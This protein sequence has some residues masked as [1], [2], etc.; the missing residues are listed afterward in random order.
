MGLRE[1][2]R[3]RDL[4]VEAVAILAGIDA[5]TVSRIERGLAQP[6]AKTVVRLAR[7]LGIG[8][9]RMRAILADVPTDEPPAVA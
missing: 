5:A 7:G 3:E 2:R 4:T 6:R 1:L 9:R 8:A